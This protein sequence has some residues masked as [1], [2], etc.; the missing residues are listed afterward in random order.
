[1][2][3]DLLGLLDLLL[4]D[5]LLGLGQDLKARA[6]GSRDRKRDYRHAETQ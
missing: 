6:P 3:F 4:L 2:L 5:D 1:V